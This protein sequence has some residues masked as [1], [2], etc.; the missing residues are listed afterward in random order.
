MSGDKWQHLESICEEAW[1]ALDGREDRLVCEL[2][3]SVLKAKA[4][5]EACKGEMSDEER[6][7]QRRVLIE[8]IK[9]AQEKIGTL[10]HD[11]RSA[12]ELSSQK[13]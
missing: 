4:G 13:N 5:F 1:N 8:M 10:L 11:R 9:D 7:A 2:V 3:L 12:L 6:G